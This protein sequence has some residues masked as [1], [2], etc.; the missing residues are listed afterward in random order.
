LNDLLGEDVIFIPVQPETKKPSLNGW[1]KITLTDSR[2]E[3]YVARLEVSNIAVLMGKPSGG[4]CSIDIDSDEDV[5]PFLELNPALV[6]TLQTKGS[7]G[8][9]IWVRIKGEFPSLTPLK[10]DEAHKWGEWRGDGGSTIIDGVHPEGMPYSRM[11]D[12]PPVEIAFADIKWP[13]NLTLP[14]VKSEYDLLV[15]E[16]GEP[17]TLASKGGLKLNQMFFV[18]KYSKEHTVLFE[19]QENAFY[20]YKAES[21][22]WLHETPH[23]LKAKFAK[24][25]KTASDAF[26]EPNMVT[27]ITDQ[28]TTALVS[29]L[30]GHSEKRGA[31]ST[32]HGLIHV[33]NGFLKLSQ[34]APEVLPFTEDYFS[35]NQIPFALDEKAECPR[36]INEVLRPILEDEDISLLR[37]W[38]GSV[39]LGRNLGQKVM[40]FSGLAGTGKSTIAEII[41]GI[42]G[43]QNVAALRTKHL[44]DRF[45]LAGFIGKTLLTGK[46][47]QGNF[48]NEEGAHMIKALSG[49]DLLD[50]E[51]KGGGK[52]PLKGHFNILL[53]SNT[54]LWMKVDGDAEAWARR[55]LIIEFDK[56]RKSKTVPN[57]AAQLLKDEGPGIL[58]WM[59]EGAM[60]LL[61]EMQQTGTYALT[62]AQQ[63]RIEKLVMEANSVRE[64][65]K[66]CV[67]KTEGHNTTTDDFVAGYVTYCQMK[68]W[69]P[70]PASMVEKQLPNAMMEI[71]MA[72]KRNDISTVNGTQRGYSGVGI[73]EEVLYGA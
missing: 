38:C 33:K 25:L 29:L 73:R 68:H 22:L 41:E 6:N 72:P 57:L 28:L 47:V 34:N 48:L 31:F 3:R 43:N 37:R 5:L 52:I 16:F 61:H 35:R 23:G 32:E 15:E 70:L 64:F 27:L 49:G 44:A 26:A 58:R 8:M 24:D 7:R 12:A 71:H 54:R 19:P 59:V 56:P 60:Q 1:N 17:Y 2:D 42:I 14:W 4:L 45:E 18:G 20:G 53:T 51:I 69:N 30:K 13:E 67:K 65:V 62:K 10:T 36:F 63:G 40:I 39:L 46:D 66:T 55:L 11:V 21:G 9:N 50:A